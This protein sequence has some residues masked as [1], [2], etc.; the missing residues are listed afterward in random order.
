MLPLDVLNGFNHHQ[1]ITILS[2]TCYNNCLQVS[3]FS[4]KMQ[5]C[6]VFY[7]NNYTG[8][9]L[10]CLLTLHTLT[11]IVFYVQK[12]RKLM[13]HTTW[14]H[15]STACCSQL[16]ITA[17]GIIAVKYK[18]WAMSQ[19]QHNQARFYVGAEGEATA[20]PNLSL[21]QMWHEAPLDELR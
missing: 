11:N 2:T 19:Y 17:L 5:K 3:F 16:K 10:N 7:Y 12:H 18:T 21:T 13:Q 1:M 14:Y 15:F 4:N 6:N 9:V 8:Q 20:S